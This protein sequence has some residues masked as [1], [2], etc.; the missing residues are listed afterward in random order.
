MSKKGVIF[1][2]IL[3]YEFSR[4]LEIYFNFLKEFYGFNS[5]KKGQKGVIISRRNYGADVA[6]HGT[7]DRATRAHADA[8]VALM[9]C[10]ADVWQGHAGPR[11]HQG[12]AYMARGSSG[13]QVM[14]PQVSGP[15]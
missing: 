6:R 10:G 4:F 1:F 8:C 14:C 9:W 3:I 11:R 7:R 2:K 12:G 15:R 13:W 5:L